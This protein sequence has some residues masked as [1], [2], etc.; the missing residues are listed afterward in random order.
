LDDGNGVVVSASPNANYVGTWTDDAGDT[1]S[2]SIVGPAPWHVSPTGGYGGPRVYS[3]GTYANNVCA[4]LT[5]PAF[6][7]GAGASLLF[8]SKFDMEA[9]YDFGV[10]EIATG[11]PFLTWKWVWVINYPYALTFGGNSCADAISPAGPSAFSGPH[12]P[13]TYYSP[14]IAGLNA[15]A[16]QTV[17]LRWHFSSDYST[18]GQG[19]WIDDVAITNVVFPVACTAGAASNPKEASPDGQMTASRTTSG[20]AVDLTYTP[21][22]GTLDNAVY[23]GEGPI[24]GA[25]VWS[26]AACALGNT[27]RSSFDPGDPPPDGLIYFVIVGQNGTKEGSYGAG[28]AGERPEAIGVGACDKPQDLTGS[29]P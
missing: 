23:W 25:V 11:P 2:A 24:N 19:W 28:T 3:T 7:L 26:H 14:Y 5:T 15:Y 20:T 8:A 6:T 17:K 4:A 13:P 29:C 22:C 16:G 10:V 9:N 27:G 12:N 21:G 1:G 18:S